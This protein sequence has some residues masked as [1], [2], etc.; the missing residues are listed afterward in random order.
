[1]LTLSAGK[2]NLNPLAVTSPFDRKNTDPSYTANLQFTPQLGADNTGLM[3]GGSYTNF[4]YDQLNNYK[5]A[6]I[7]GGYAGFGIAGFTILGEFDIAPRYLN[8]L[9]D[10]ISK[11]SSSTAL[12]IEGAYEL[13]KGLQAVVRY[14][15][16]DPSTDIDK[17]EVSR[18]ILG[19]EIFPYSFIEI[20][21]Q[22]RL[23]MDASDK[24]PKV[25]KDSFVLQFHF[26][27]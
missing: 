11:D 24:D 27:Y 19:F 14:D 7:F 22:Y 25:N 6:N 21:P 26:W 10:N 8:V 1:L 16:F 12:M 17:D 5:N 2:P 20:R 13:I 9:P 4:K 15:R 23:Q 3:F 18:L